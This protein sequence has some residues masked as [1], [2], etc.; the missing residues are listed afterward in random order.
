MRCP[1]G[2][3]HHSPDT[4]VR[5]PCSACMRRFG[6]QIVA[7]IERLGAEAVEA[8]MNGSLRV[9]MGLSG[10]IVGLLALVL[11]KGEQLA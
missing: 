8:D 9:R 2:F 10:V 3:D 7:D 5:A 11:A 1:L 6:E 4:C